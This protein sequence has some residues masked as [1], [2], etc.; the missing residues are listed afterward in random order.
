MNRN[1]TKQ[2]TENMD[3]KEVCLDILRDLYSASRQLMMYPM[4]HPVTNDTLL[5]PL[6][7]LNAIFSFKKSFVIQVYNGRL[8][9]EGLL[10][11]NTVFV[12]GLMHDIIF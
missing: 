12:E 6:D 5:K 8:V 1:I 4:G 3:I 2:E 7:R 11:E 10:L 9:C